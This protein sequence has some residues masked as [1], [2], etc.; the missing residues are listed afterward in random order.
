MNAKRSKLDPTIQWAP[1]E[2]ITVFIVMEG[3]LNELERG[4][5][6]SIFLNFAIA[7]G[8]IAVSLLTTLLTATSFSLPVLCILVC[9]TSVC[10]IAALVLI[11]IWWQSRKG[12]RSVIKEIR[13]RRPPDEG[14]QAGGEVLEPNNS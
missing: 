7:T 2:K 6:D 9:I 1:I 14:F 8:S 4:S 13:R 12:V 3:E 10:G 11:A 5:P